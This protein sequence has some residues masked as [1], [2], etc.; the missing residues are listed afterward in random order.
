MVGIQFYVIESNLI[1]NRI[2]IKTLDRLLSRQVLYYTIACLTK[3]IIYSKLAVS[4]TK[5]S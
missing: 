3:L 1:C 4:V 5:T 2:R